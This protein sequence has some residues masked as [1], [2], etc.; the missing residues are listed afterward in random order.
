MLTARQ[1]AESDKG[2]LSLLS[3]T[4]CQFKP[5]GQPGSNSFQLHKRLEVPGDGDGGLGG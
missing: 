2:F 1:A 5:G 4:C 3:V